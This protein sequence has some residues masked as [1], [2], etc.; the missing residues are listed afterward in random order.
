MQGSAELFKFDTLQ[1]DIPIY[2]ADLSTEGIRE[3]SQH[4]SG[5]AQSGASDDMFAMPVACAES[6]LAPSMKP[7]AVGFQVTRPPG[8]LSWS[9][10]G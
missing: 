5:M 10:K 3:D 1:D 6:D 7:Y 9:F 2:E 4:Q 8:T